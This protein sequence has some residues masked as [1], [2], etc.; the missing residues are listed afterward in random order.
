MAGE[1]P[2]H[3]ESVIWT[4]LDCV[5]TLWGVVTTWQFFWAADGEGKTLGAV[6]P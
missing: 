4:T 3:L 2:E 1:R 6:G 5:E